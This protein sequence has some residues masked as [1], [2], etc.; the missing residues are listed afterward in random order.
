MA[1]SKRVI[2]TGTMSFFEGDIVNIFL[3]GA[4]HKMVVGKLTMIG[5]ESFRIDAS[6]R[7]HANVEEHPISEI[8]L[9]SLEER[10]WA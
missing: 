5:S 2:Y 10:T 8:D 3:K 9:I 1:E 7:Y 6:E 4:D